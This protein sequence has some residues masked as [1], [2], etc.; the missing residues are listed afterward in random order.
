[1]KVDAAVATLNSLREQG[2]AF[3]RDW[4]EEDK[5]NFAKRYMAEVQ[6]LQGFMNENF[7]ETDFGNDYSA[8]LDFQKAEQIAWF[9]LAD[10]QLAFYLDFDQRVEHAM[11]SG[12]FY[13]THHITDG[14][15]LNLTKEGAFEIAENY[16]AKYGSEE[17]TIEDIDEDVS[18]YNADDY[19]DGPV[20]I[21]D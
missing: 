10:P 8:L 5:I 20:W 1:M 16:K 11:N 7:P 4:S 13:F 3:P 9:F 18:F 17:D 19:I 6:R 12:G 21:V 2:V 15:E 14:L